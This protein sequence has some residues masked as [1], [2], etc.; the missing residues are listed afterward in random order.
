V[1]VVGGGDGGQWE[2]V[3]LRW[4]HVFEDYHTPGDVVSIHPI[5]SHRSSILIHSI[6]IDGLNQ[7][8]SIPR[9]TIEKIP[10]FDTPVKSP[11]GQRYFGKDDTASP[12]SKAALWPSN[13]HRE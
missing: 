9:G 10:S 7:K 1:P 4:G 13:L 5:D 3:N 11:K 6:G 8:F 12:E 2:L